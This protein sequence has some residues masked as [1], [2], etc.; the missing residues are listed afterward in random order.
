MPDRDPYSTAAAAERL[1]AWRSTADPH[2]RD[3]RYAE[4]LRRQFSKQ[5][6]DDGPS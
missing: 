3:R 6:D 2:E 4:V 1:A 5:T